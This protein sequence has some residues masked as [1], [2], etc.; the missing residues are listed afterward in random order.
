MARWLFAVAMGAALLAPVRAIEQ[1]T[2][3]EAAS[4]TGGQTFGNSQC[5][6]VGYCTM[7]EPCHG[8][9]EN[10]VC[11]AIYDHAQRYIC[12]LGIMNCFEYWN[13]Y[14]GDGCVD[15]YAYFYG[16]YNEDQG[17]CYD[18]CTSGI[19]GIVYSCCID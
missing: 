7:S 17:G 8:P 11:R 2:S 10:G 15:C 13:N 12:G 3:A 1:L 4:V 16:D 14:G 5:D 9:I 6:L 19:N 18:Q